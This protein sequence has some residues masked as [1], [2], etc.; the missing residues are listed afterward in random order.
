MSLDGFMSGPNGEFDWPLADEEFEWAAKGILDSA[1]TLLLGRNTYQMFYR[2]WPS[3]ISLTAGKMQGP[4]GTEFIVPTKPNT[5]HEEVA[6]KMNEYRK[7][8]FSKFTR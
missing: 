3:A 4:D 6:R 5:A 2:Y 7:M 1:D 8:V